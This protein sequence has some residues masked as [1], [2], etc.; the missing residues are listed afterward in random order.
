MNAPCIR[1]ELE[2]ADGSRQVATGQAA[3]QIRSWLE[4][5]QFFTVSDGPVYDGPQFQFIPPSALRGDQE[6][7]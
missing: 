4:T 7:A 1:I 3:E 2:Y 5:C 6:S